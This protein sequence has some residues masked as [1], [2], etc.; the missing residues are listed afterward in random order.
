MT[1]HCNLRVSLEDM[2]RISF[3][4]MSLETVET[5][6]Q[7]IVDAAFILLTTNY[8]FIVVQ[9]T[10]CVLEKASPDIT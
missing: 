5:S 1:K 3:L 4:I 8:M 7:L 10:Q 2:L 9:N 6:I